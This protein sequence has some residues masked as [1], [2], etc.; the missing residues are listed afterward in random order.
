MEFHIQ[1]NKA[2]DAFS[3]IMNQLGTSPKNPDEL[4][5]SISHKVDDAETFISR[6]HR[7]DNIPIE[8]NE[9]QDFYR[10]DLEYE[11]DTDE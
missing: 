11:S 5:D 1:S 4:E 7:A 6:L 10:T 9:D 2:A 3:M 8:K